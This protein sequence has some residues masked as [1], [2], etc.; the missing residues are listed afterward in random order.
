MAITYTPISTQ[1]LGSN[2]A[3]VTFS[4]IPATYTD[5][6]V[7]F[8]GGV[9]GNNS[10]WFYLNGDT[11]TKYSGTFI[12]GNGTGVN[13]L[14]T[15]NVSNTGN[16]MAFYN[17]G[18]QSLANQ[19]NMNLMNYANTT[20]NKT[21]ITRSGGGAYETE[22]W[23]NLYRSTSAITSITYGAQSTGNYLAGSMFTLYG[24]KAA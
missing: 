4:S 3:T 11:T 10:L 13:T 5:L 9:T 2:T 12:A 20:T 18:P 1:T 24:I 7:V 6:V 17:V 23:V 15:A 16:L 22:I 14:N 19:F 21:T 8:V